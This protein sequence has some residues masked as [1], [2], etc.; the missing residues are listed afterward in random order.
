MT[1]IVDKLIAAHAD[2]PFVTATNKRDVRASLDEIRDVI[3]GMDDFS[4]FPEGASGA[5][6]YALLKAA[7]RRCPDLG[8]F[9]HV[10][11]GY[12]AALGAAFVVLR[13][14]TAWFPGTDT[15]P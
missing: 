11:Q 14:E 10:H 1:S 7:S 13:D 2:G 8:D 4:R 6:L 5:I 15:P 9:D 3:E 12:Q